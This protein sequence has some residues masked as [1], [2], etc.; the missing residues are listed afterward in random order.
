MDSV[1]NLVESLKCLRNEIQFNKIFE[2]CSELT[3]MVG[4]ELKKPRTALHSVYIPAAGVTD[5]VNPVEDN[6]R[7]NFFY[8]AVDNVKE[9]LKHMFRD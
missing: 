1:E 2:E 7:C 3:D 9:D 4:I 5:C 8:P 6:Y